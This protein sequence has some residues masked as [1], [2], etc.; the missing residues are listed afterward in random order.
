MELQE[1]IPLGNS[2]AFLAI[3]VTRFNGF[4]IKNVMIS[5]RMVIYVMVTH[6]LHN[7]NCCGTHLPYVMLSQADRSPSL[8]PILHGSLLNQFWSALWHKTITYEK[9]TLQQLFFENLRISR[10]TAW[11]FLLFRGYK[12]GS[13]LWNIILWNYF[14]S[15]FV[16]KSNHICVTLHN[17]LKYFRNA[18]EMN[19]MNR[20]S[21]NAAYP[22]AI[23]DLE[24]RFRASSGGG[25]AIWE[26]A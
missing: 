12:I 5:K 14:R 22:A 10:V 24:L 4:R 11:K 1:I 2:Q 25:V 17:D 3:T 15:N 6:L 19:G 8:R 9:T 18:F 20:S 23:C 7:M 16:S 21:Q 26:A 13:K